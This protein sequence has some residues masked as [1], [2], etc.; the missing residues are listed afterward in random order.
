MRFIGQNSY[1]LLAIARTDIRCSPE[2]PPSRG[3]HKLHAEVP[4]R[5]I[6][7][8]YPVKNLTL[9]PEFASAFQW[10][11]LSKR[12]ARNSRKPRTKHHT[13]SVGDWAFES[14]RNCQYDASDQS[15]F[16]SR[17]IVPPPDHGSQLMNR[18]IQWAPSAPIKRTIRTRDSRDTRVYGSPIC[19]IRQQGLR[20]RLGQQSEASPPLVRG[21][22]SQ[23][24]FVSILSGGESL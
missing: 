23:H 24:S 4:F 2:T 10:S 12:H 6:Q 5:T 7:T 9:L 17:N 3:L 11:R 8:G 20:R 19:D 1:R 15:H 21:D 14:Y 13:R 22:T 16:L 18:P